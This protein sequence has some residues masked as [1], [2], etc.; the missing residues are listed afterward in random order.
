MSNTISTPLPR[1]STVVS[2]TGWVHAG[3]ITTPS[4][5]SFK[6][7]VKDSMDEVVDAFKD[8][9]AACVALKEATW[10]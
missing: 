1:S 5:V 4:T 7:T 2:T 10:A 3:N 8:L 9:A 6:T